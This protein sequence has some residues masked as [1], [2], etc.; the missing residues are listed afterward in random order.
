MEISAENK[1]RQ[2][3]PEGGQGKRPEA[4]YRASFKYRRADVSKDGSKRDSFSR[5]AQDKASCE[6]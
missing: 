4:E 2:W 3:H 5:A 6:T 1:H